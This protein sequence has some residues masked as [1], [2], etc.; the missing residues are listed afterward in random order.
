M[1]LDYNKTKKYSIF[2]KDQNMSS[3]NLSWYFYLTQNGL[4]KISQ[5]ILN[6]LYKKIGYFN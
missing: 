5:E 2:E 6:F 4:F 1:S 3:R